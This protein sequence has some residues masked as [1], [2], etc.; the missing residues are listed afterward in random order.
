MFMACKICLIVALNVCVF[1]L[2]RCFS[3]SYFWGFVA[4]YFHVSSFHCC[5]TFLSYSILN[6][7]EAGWSK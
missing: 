2:L 1:Y 4:C 5:L 3:S 7:K 6:E